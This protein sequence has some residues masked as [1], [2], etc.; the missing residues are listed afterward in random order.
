MAP[1]V[2]QYNRLMNTLTKNARL[3]L[4]RDVFLYTYDWRQPM[5]KQGD[6][7]KDY[8]EKILKSKPAGT[9]FRL[10]GHSL[11]GLVVRSY[12]A[13]NPNLHSVEKAM[14]VGTPHEGTVLA[15][16]VWEKGEIWSDDRL[17][18]LAL[19]QIINY[20][21]II[22]TNL[23]PQPRI[24]QIILKSNREVAQ[25][26]VPS[27]KSLLPVFP[28]LRQNGETKPI[29]S[30]QNKNEWLPA[31]QFS[32][33]IPLEDLFTLSGGNKPTLRYLEVVP[34]SFTDSS[35]GNWMANRLVVKKF[36]K[37]MAQF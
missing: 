19:S 28:F 18:K 17:M 15:Y 12:I 34:P 27:L 21:R 37:A 20:C 10:V 16:P 4:N 1:Y 31:H 9:K 32:G 3:K 6:L 35:L 24:P 8:L 36:G 25:K 30:A 33:N 5:D 11:G 2:S 22:M 26:V 13:N 29:T 14:T 7:L 23:S